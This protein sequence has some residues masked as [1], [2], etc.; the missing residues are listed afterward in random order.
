MLSKKIRLSESFTIKMAILIK[1]EKNIC[2]RKVLID[3][4]K[5]KI[6][7]PVISKVSYLFNTLFMI[8]RNFSTKMEL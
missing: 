2:K 4:Q 1:V 8:K 7:T 3:S 6:N 5:K